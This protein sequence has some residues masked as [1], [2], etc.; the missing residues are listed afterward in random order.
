MYFLLCEPHRLAGQVLNPLSW[1][2]SLGDRVAMP[3][4]GEH[5]PLRPLGCPSSPPQTQ[6]P[7][8]DSV[9]YGMV[10]R[11]DLTTWGSQV[12]LVPLWTLWEPL[13]PIEAAAVCPPWA[14]RGHVDG[15][16]TPAAA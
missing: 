16:E 6:S 8:R 14:P 4:P 10:P 9:T 13:V 15:A 3:A 1:N 2:L 12:S 5:L 7:P 11:A